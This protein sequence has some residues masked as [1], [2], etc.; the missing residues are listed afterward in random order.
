LSALHPCRYLKDVKIGG[1]LSLAQA[2]A[3]QL[4]PKLQSERRL[5]EADMAAVLKKV[6]IKLGGGKL[7]VALGDVLPAAGV[8]DMERICEDYARSC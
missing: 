3:A 5:D 2:L 6:P 4:G 1:G 8:R 7:T